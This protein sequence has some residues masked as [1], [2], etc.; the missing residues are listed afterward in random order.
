MVAAGPSLDP[1]CPLGSVALLGLNA[2]EVVCKASFR[3]TPPGPV[4]GPPNN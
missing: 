1:G 3:L 4:G 2:E